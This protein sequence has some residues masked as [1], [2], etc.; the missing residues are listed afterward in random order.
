MTEDP[1]HKSPEERYE[2]PFTRTLGKILKFAT[3]AVGFA[4][5]GFLILRFL[6]C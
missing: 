5:V 2:G 4:V 1:R 6:H 3:L